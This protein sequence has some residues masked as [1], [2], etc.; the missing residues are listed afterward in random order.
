MTVSYPSKPKNFTITP[1]RRKLCKQLAR[2]QH[3]G[4]A[5][6][7]LSH[8]LIRQNVVK[9]M[10]KIVQKE[11]ALL[12]SDKVTSVLQDRSGTELL[13]F[14]WERIHRELEE[15]TPN[16]LTLLKWC[17]K[18]RTTRNDRPRV[19]VICLCISMLCKFRNSRMSLTQKVL[20][21]LLYA[22]HASKQVEMLTQLYL[23]VI[24]VMLYIAIHTFGKVDV[25]CI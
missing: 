20:S 5:K 14:S 4:T 12:C 6:Q 7:C 16:L 3:K 25:D 13:E 9:E 10:G 23:H 1:S 17:T 22:G 15:Y 8:N 18:T 19:A 24:V 21:L 2:R 11:I